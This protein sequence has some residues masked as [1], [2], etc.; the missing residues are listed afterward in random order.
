MAAGRTSTAGRSHDSALQATERTP[1]FVTWFKADDKFHGHRKT[2][3]ALRHP[4]K[5]RDAAAVGLWTLAGTWSADNL[6][7]GF[8]PSDE[9]FRWDDDAE[10]LAD[11]LV[12]AELWTRAEVHGEPGFQFVNWEEWQPTKATVE[13]KREQARERMKA[14]RDNKPKRSKP[15]RANR[16]R[17]AREVRST[18][19]RPVPSLAAAAAAASSD[20]DPKPTVADDLPAAVE[21]LRSALE[22][23][24]LVVRWDRLTVEEL[25]EIEALVATHGDAPLVRSALQEYQPNQPLVFA[26]GYLGGWRQIRKPG[27][28]AAV[29]P[30][31]QPGHAGTVRHCTQC[32]SEQKAAN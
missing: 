29:D 3:K 8:V 31:T 26:A 20:G 28:L 14:V 1:S 13:G 5:R 16:P 17:S 12:E 23:R 22:A 10:G 15:V 30:C 21:I 18:P 7:D 9:L 24:K 6:T 4:E 25:T 27:E 32:A 11:R 19:S 2:R